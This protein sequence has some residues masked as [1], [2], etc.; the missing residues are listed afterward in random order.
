MKQFKN[1]FEVL[2]YHSKCPFC[3]GKMSAGWD[4]A[5]DENS[6]KAY[7][8]FGLT[9]LTVDCYNNNIIECRQTSNNNTIYGI[10]GIGPA[11]QYVG[12]SL[13]DLSSHGIDIRRLNISCDGCSKYSYLIQIHISLEHGRV[14]ALVLNS[15]SASIEE[16]AKLYEI[17]NIYVTEKTEMSIF[18]THTSQQRGA[19]DKIE[20]PLVPLDLQNPLK[21]VERIKNLLVF[22]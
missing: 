21:T 4:M 2:N 3:S 15:E 14:V 7:L 19:L 10:G 22:L 6:V 11:V 8:K 20:L 12:S 17:K 18:H 5:Y 1:L 9:T 13:S 16:G